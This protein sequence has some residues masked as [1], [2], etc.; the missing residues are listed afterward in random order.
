MLKWVSNPKYYRIDKYLN[1]G[2]VNFIRSSEYVRYKMCKLH[3][4]I[5]SCNSLKMT[6]LDLNILLLR[7]SLVS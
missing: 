3:G 7:E 4:K 6:I 5:D 2:N 1:N